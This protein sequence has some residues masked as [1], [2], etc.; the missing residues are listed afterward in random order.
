[1][2][3]FIHAAL[4]TRYC[5]FTVGSLPRAVTIPDDTEAAALR[6][7]LEA[8]VK[9]GEDAEV[10]AAAARR[11]VQATRLLLEESKATALEQTATTTQQ[12]V[13]SSSSSSSSS[14]AASQLVPTASSTY[15]DTVVVGLHLQA[16]TVLNVR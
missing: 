14:A 5:L 11:R 10:Q 13:P 9:E 7:W 4:F 15:E 1:M 16:A 3:L 12:R 2:T 6:A 8:I